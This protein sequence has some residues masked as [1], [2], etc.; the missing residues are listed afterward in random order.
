MLVM[1]FCPLMEEALALPSFSE[2][3]FFWCPSCFPDVSHPQ[4]LLEAG[5]SA[6]C[7]NFQGSILWDVMIWQHW[8]LQRGPAIFQLQGRRMCVQS[9]RENR[10]W[11][12]EEP[13]FCF[14]SSWFPLDFIFSFPCC[15]TH[16]SS[17][18][19]AWRWQ[20]PHF[21]AFCRTQCCQLMTSQRMLPWKLQQE[22]IFPACRSLTQ[23]SFI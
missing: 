17:C 11:S 21:P 20:D 3:M 13:H 23:A 7:C 4:F 12:Q 15:T 19:V 2:R 22:A 8:L 5:K 6:S 9:N 1:C 18:L 16:I 14:S 10:R